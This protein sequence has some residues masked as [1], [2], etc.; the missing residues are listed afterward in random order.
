MIITTK[1]QLIKNLDRIESYLSSN[2]NELYNTMANYIARGREFV[3]YIVNEKM[4]FAPS[5]F[6]GYQNNTL[7]KHQNNDDKD[8][9]ITTPAISKIIGS[10]NLFYEELEDAYLTY[11]EWLGVTA[12]NNNRTYWLLEDRILNEI[13]TQPLVE[14]A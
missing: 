9:K 14:G 10:K 7:I 1:T 3:C 4:H 8:G 11:C 5:R 13:T 6:V 12:S 2:S